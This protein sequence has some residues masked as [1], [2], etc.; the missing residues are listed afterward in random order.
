VKERASVTRAIGT[1]ALTPSDPARVA[2]SSLLVVAPG[3]EMLGFDID[4][5][6]RERVITGAIAKLN[7]K[8]VFP[9]TAKRMEQT[10]HRHQ[11][12]GAYDAVAKGDKFAALLTTHLRDVSHDKHLRVEFS[13]AKQPDVAAAPAAY[14]PRTTASDSS[15]ATVSSRRW[16]SCPGISARVASR[17]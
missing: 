17:Q 11:K 8:Y 7:E 9:D 13:P 15:A 12:G 3:G 5:A 4:V 10:L 16:R 14:R 1:F 2:A 6:T